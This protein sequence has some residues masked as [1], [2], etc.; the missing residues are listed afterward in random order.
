MNGDDG[1]RGYPVCRAGAAAR[2]GSVRSRRLR[3]KR[4]RRPLTRVTSRKGPPRS[5]P[6]I[7]PTCVNATSRPRA[8]KPTRL[9][10]PRLVRHL[11]R[12]PRPRRRTIANVRRSKASRASIAPS[13]TGR[14]QCRPRRRSHRR[15]R[16]RTRTTDGR[17][18][19]VAASAAARQCALRC[20][21]SRAPWPRVT[22][23][24]AGRCGRAASGAAANGAMARRARASIRRRCASIRWRWALQQGSGRR[25]GPSDQRAPPNA[26][27][28]AAHRDRP[29]GREHPA[30]HAHRRA[31]ADRG[32]RRTR[33]RAGARRG[34]AG[35]RRRLPARGHG[36]QSHVG[37]PARTRRRLLHRDAPRPR[38]SGSRRRCCC[39]RRTSPAGAGT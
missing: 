39:L 8:T 21:A 7:R 20:A 10:S 37:A 17:R 25:R 16:F 5:S 36:D 13:I 14:R 15:C 30:H 9:S 35:R 24:S 22:A 2:R 3:S 28:F 6:R 11:N 12:R 26:V 27:G 31:G 23:D 38:R 34:T 29:A 18:P 4:S 19:V 32:A 33:R 1:A